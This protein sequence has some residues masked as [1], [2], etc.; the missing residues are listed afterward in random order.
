MRLSLFCLPTQ[1]EVPSDVKMSSHIL[2][3]RSGMIR[4]ETAGI[5]TWLPLG[6]RVLKKIESVI[7]KEHEKENINQMLMPTIQSA[8]I[9]KKSQR[10]ESYGKEML[11]ILDRN[12][13]ELLYG[14]T[15][16]EMMTEIGLNIIKSYKS[17]PLSFFHIQSKFRDEIRPRFGV[18]RSRE[19]LM[20]DAYSFDLSASNLKITYN[21]FFKLYMK[22]FKI[23]GMHV[24]PV[25]ALSGEIGGDLSHEFHLVSET[26]ESQIMISEELENSLLSFS[27]DNF[28]KNY[29]SSTLEFYDH[30]KIMD[31]NLIKKNSI[32]LGH[33]F[34]F[35]DKYTKKFNFLID[36][37]DGRI[38][39]LMGSYGIGISRIPAAI[40]E[41]NH[42]QK[43]IMWPKEIA[44]FDV[45]IL[46]LKNGQQELDEFCNNIYHELNNRGIDV[47]FDDRDERTG[48]KF[49]DADLIGIPYQIIVGKNF[50]E[51]D[52]IQI[53][54]RSSGKEIQINS[55]KL[56]PKI[57]SLI[58]HD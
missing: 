36:T 21:K 25:K 24:L 8:E 10:Y 13:K 54:E 27:Y 44:P 12:N 51:E 52:I 17:L 55:Q 43:G 58:N 26:G 40:I 16:E 34:S 33:I 39:P 3:I 49:S 56:I 22:I 30:N 48:I 5:Y 7:I 50:L 57:I 29:F 41:N 38:N 37:P 1:K 6:F 15:N 42:D 18:M 19:F 53:K 4:M 14:P 31:K 47:L 9:W 45:L 35:G 32:E 28:E 23:L 11:R 20:K 46:S 2:M